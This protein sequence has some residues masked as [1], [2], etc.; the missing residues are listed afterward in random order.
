MPLEPPVMSTW[1]SRM[2]EG[3]AK[4]FGAQGLEILELFCREKA[5]RQ[6]AF[7]L[8]DEL[9]P[10]ALVGRVR[11]PAGVVPLVTRP[12]GLATVDAH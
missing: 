1:R 8:V 6:T 9:V 2:T 3:L 12:L 10:V 11:I 4:G 7:G 5:A